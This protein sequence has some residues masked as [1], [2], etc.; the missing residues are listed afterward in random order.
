VV[1]VNAQPT[2]FDQ[3]ADAVIDAPIGEVLP[4]LLG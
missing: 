3:I 4:V 2:Q 1:I